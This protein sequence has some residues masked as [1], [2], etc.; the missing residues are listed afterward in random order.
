MPLAFSR[1]DRAVDFALDKGCWA[2]CAC[3]EVYEGV[4]VEL[5]IEELLEFSCGDGSG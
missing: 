4:G 2:A 1:F 3:A 5:I